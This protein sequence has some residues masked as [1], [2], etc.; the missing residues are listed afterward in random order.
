[1]GDEVQHSVLAY[2]VPC[3]FSD[4]D[5]FLEDEDPIGSF[6]HVFELG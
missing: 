2:V 4:D 6:D 1:M 5:S 3:Q